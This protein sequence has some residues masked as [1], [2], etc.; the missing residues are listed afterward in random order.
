[1][2]NKP[3]LNWFEAFTVKAILNGELRYGFWWSDL[4]LCY[5][6]THDDY[7]DMDIFRA[8][9]NALNRLIELGWLTKWSDVGQIWYTFDVPFKPDFEEIP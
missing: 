4:I 2:N 5:A 9:S 3:V 1:M 6:K 8:F 7:D